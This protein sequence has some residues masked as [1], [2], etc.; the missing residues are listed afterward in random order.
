MS[1]SASTNKVREKDLESSAI[2]L[3]KSAESSLLV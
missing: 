3:Y 1:S 2:K